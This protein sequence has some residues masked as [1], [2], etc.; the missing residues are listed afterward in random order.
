MQR[1]GI[2]DYGM[3]NL[4]SVAGAV[5]YLGYEAVVSHDPRALAETDRLILPGVGAF[6]DAMRNLHARGLVDALGDLVRRRGTPLLGICL[7]AQLLARESEEF[8][9]H[10]GLGWLDATVSRL[11]PNDPAL[12]VPHVGWNGI[13][14][15]RDG[16][17]LK[18]VPDDALFYYVHSY[19][20]G[21]APAG[22][23]LC[24][25]DYG[26]RFAAVLE[27]G[28]VFA[29]Q[30]HPEKSQQHGLTMLRNFLSV[31]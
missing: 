16:V 24:E 2:V 3:G 22:N 27:S 13:R 31:H 21:D 12:R 6:P 4:V 19:C 26:A 30:F 1:V 20:I 15:I 10:A 14:K 9:R 25:C 17:L 5:E 23:V 8:G 7:G 29:T 28:R 18:G 11:R